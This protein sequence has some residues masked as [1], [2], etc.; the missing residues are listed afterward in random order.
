MSA[1]RKHAAD[2][3]APKPRAR[4]PRPELAGADAASQPSPALALQQR[5]AVELAEAS[6]Y[7]ERWSGR[8][9]MT[10][11]LGSASVLWAG[12]LAVGSLIF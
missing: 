5:L 9:R 6:P 1:R 7:E 10:V 2:P 4:G 3:A 12:L 8:M 11:L